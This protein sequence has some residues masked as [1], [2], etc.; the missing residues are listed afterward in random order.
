[1]P[2]YFYEDEILSVVSAFET[3]KNYHGRKIIF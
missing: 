3:Q 1:M 2:K